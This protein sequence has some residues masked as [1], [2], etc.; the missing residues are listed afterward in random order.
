MEP[1]KPLHKAGLAPCLQDYQQ[2][3]QQDEYGLHQ[4]LPGRGRNLMIFGG[5]L[6]IEDSLK[7]IG[8]AGESDGVDLKQNSQLF[9]QQNRCIRE[10]QRTAI[11]YIHPMANHKQIWREGRTD[12]DRVG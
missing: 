2:A 7:S 11:W 8:F 1:I 5:T 9:Y 10:Q 3:Y 6:K 12:R 4:P